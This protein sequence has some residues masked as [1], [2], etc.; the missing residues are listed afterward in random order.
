[1]KAWS[2]NDN[3]LRLEAGLPIITRMLAVKRK[4]V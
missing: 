1:M 2:D 3:L 4:C